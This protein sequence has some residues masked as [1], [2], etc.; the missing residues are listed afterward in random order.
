MTREQGAFRP[1]DLRPSSTNYRLISNPCGRRLGP[2]IMRSLIDS[3]TIGRRAQ[4][5]SID[6]VKPCSPRTRKACWLPS[7]ALPSIRS[8]RT[9]CGCARCLTT[10]PISWWNTLR[11][12]RGFWVLKL[13]LPRSSRLAVLH[14]TVKRAENE[15][16]QPVRSD[17]QANEH[18]P[19][20]L[21]S[22][23]LTLDRALHTNGYPE[24]DRVVA[25]ER[26][27]VVASF[28]EHR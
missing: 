7:A 15:V 14:T 19:I 12:D 22:P 11:L 27:R 25:S 20:K 13:I 17:P 16:H 10:W 6:P 4:C 18:R 23:V 9:R 1:C 5:F 26:D 28:S 3:R 2:K 24:R 21:L 8:S